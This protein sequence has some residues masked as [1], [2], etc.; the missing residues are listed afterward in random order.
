MNS[1]GKKMKLF[2]TKSPLWLAVIAN[3]NHST[4]LLDTAFV[5]TVGKFL[6]ENQ[7]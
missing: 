6:Q 3:T 1:A 2:I 5:Q 7:N 4:V